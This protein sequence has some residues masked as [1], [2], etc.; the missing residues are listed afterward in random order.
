[1]KMK[2]NVLFIVFLFVAIL[3]R[4]SLSETAEIDL[5]GTARIAGT[6]KDLSGLKGLFNDGSAM[7]QLGGFGSAITYTGSGNRYLALADRGPKD[8]QIP[9]DCR[10][11]EFEISIGPHLRPS[12]QVKLRRTF[13]LKNEAGETYVGSASHF[14]VA[15]SS[16]G[17]RLDPEGIAIGPA[18]TIFISDEYGP[19]INEFTPD[20]RWLRSLDIPSQFQI[21]TPKA[22]KKEE[23]AANHYGRRTNKG[24]EGLTLSIDKKKLYA[25]L[26]GPLLQDSKDVCRLLEIDLK[27]GKTRQFVVPLTKKEYGFNEILALNDHEFLAIERDDEKG[28]AS[29]FKRIVKLNIADVTDVQSIAAIPSD[30]KKTIKPVKKVT[31]LDFLN[32]RFG[33]AGISFP[34][35]IEGMTW[36]PDLPDGRHILIVT[37]D[38]DCQLMQPSEFWVFAVRL[39]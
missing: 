15:N 13:L 24:F 14:D 38:N 25:I 12:V 36:G 29:A 34:E 27:T 37:T 35:K 8:G 39:N 23:I 1:M 16:A 31:W 21:K 32:P 26:Q 30:W 20:G 2:I 19:F 5:V 9:Y 6:A 3:A 28:T 4:T 7:D 11:H 17:L 22:N 10:F 18:G 33:L